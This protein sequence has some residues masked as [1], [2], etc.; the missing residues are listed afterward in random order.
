MEDRAYDPVKVTVMD[1]E[2]CTVCEKVWA[3]FGFAI[4]LGFLFI[5][6]DLLTG[7]SISR[8]IGGR[9]SDDNG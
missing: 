7:G 6:V 5:S 3:I 1:D 8:A 4:A 2:E 9:K